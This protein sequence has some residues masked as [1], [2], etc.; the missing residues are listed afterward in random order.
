MRVMVAEAGS[1][2]Q[3]SIKEIKLVECTQLQC[4]ANDTWNHAPHRSEIVLLQ[5]SFKRKRAHA[6]H[7]LQIHMV[8]LELHNVK[9]ENHLPHM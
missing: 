3:Y 9:Q 6:P 7:F 1:L 5:Q 2:I 4:R 8:L